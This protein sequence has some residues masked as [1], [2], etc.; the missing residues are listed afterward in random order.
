MPLQACLEGASGRQVSS[1]H[2]LLDFSDA[3]GR[4]RAA[5]RVKFESQGR[6]KLVEDCLYLNVLTSPD[7]PEKRGRNKKRPVMV[8]IHGGGNFVGASNG[9]DGRALALQNDA[10]VVLW[11]ASSKVDAAPKRCCRRDG[12][13]RTATTRRYVT[14]AKTS[15]SQGREHS[16]GRWRIKAE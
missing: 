7:A 11:D 10:V 15:R 1:G 9:H 14:C 16:A 13:D 12:V 4:G 8:W 2:F 5:P 6:E 3:C